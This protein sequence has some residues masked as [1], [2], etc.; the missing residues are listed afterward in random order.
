MKARCSG[1]G[2]V[3]E[4]QAPV[5]LVVCHCGKILKLRPK[6]TDFVVEP[7]ESVSVDHYKTLGLARP[8]TEEDVRVAYR[9]RAK[10]CH[11]DRGGDAAEFDLITIAYKTLRDPETRRAYDVQIDSGRTNSVS[12][13]TVPDL[14]AKRGSDLETALDGLQLVPQVMVVPVSARDPR[15]RRVVG[16]YPYPGSLVESWSAVGIIV[17]VPRS[18]TVWEHLKAYGAEIAE[19]FFDGLIRGG[20]GN[21][22]DRRELGSGESALGPQLAGAVGEV[23]GATAKAGV[24][25]ASCMLRIWLTAIGLLLA[26]ALTVASPPLGAIFLIVILVMAVKS[27]ISRSDRK[28]RGVWY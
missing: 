25:V 1:C 20:G 4:S 13:E 17:A 3:S 12:T 27:Q 2:L 18:S 15:V 14:I 22:T 9:R 8:V 7:K 11:P 16:Q 6:P 5:L 24:G 28:S 23:V 10:E 19:S 26:G 21:S